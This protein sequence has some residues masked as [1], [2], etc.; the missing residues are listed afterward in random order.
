MKRSVLTDDPKLIKKKPQH[1]DVQ[2]VGPTGLYV[3]VVFSLLAVTK[4]T[5]LGGKI[6]TE[7]ASQ[8]HVWFGKVFI[9]RS[10]F[11]ML[12]LQGCQID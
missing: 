1:I 3:T 2:R 11:T 4:N 5:Q 6:N 10:R 9:R 7:R 8:T 12:I